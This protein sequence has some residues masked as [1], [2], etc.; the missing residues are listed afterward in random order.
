MVITFLAALRTGR[1][2]DK[3]EGV[4]GWESE[5]LISGHALPSGCVIDH[6][7]GCQAKFYVNLSSWGRE[8]QMLLL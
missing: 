7:C 6:L 2:N 1:Q 3:K 5:G 4:L 8:S